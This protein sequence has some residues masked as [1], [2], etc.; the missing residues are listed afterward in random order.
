MLAIWRTCGL[1]VILHYVAGAL[2]AVFSCAFVVLIWLGVRKIPLSAQAA[3]S[4]G[5]LLTAMGSVGL[6]AGW[7]MACVLVHAGRSIDLRRR[8]RWCQ[9]VAALS[10]PWFPFGTG[11]GIFTLILLG[12]SHTARAQLGEDAPVPPAPAPT[13]F[14]D[15][16]A[17]AGWVSPEAKRRF[18]AGDPRRR[19]SPSSFSSRCRR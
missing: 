5:P 7:T 9:V 6:V 11:L 2:L 15:D 10:M 17:W 4:A 13:P 12:V 16:A 8:L 3:A 19:R 14:A 18:A 1:V